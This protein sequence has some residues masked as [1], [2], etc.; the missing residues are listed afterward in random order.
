MNVRI[1]LPEGKSKAKVVLTDPHDPA[2]RSWEVAAEVDGDV[3]RFAMFT[4]Q[5]YGLA[6]VMFA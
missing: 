2:H 6:Q 4:P 3:V 1:A 5:V